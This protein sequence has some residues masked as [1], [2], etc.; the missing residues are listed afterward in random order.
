MAK[1]DGI[2]PFFIM[3][4]LPVGVAGLIIAAV[5]AASQSSISSSLNS[6]A[7]AWTKDVDSIGDNAYNH[8]RFERSA[9]L[10]PSVDHPVSY[11]HLTLPTKA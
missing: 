11:T 2:L 9:H 5:F 8:V 3:Q 4:Q 6:I 1:S 7:T 10:S